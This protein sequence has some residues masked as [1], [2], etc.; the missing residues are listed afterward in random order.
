MDR[1]GMVLLSEQFRAY[2][3]T[4]SA[5]ALSTLESTMQVAFGVKNLR[6]VQ[7]WTRVGAVQRNFINPSIGTNDI[8]SRIAFVRG[9]LEDRVPSFP[10]KIAEFDS[11]PTQN[12]LKL[13]EYLANPYTRSA[14]SRILINPDGNIAYEYDM[15]GFG[16]NDDVVDEDD[17]EEFR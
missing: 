4:L 12:G 16:W 9:I 5:F 11:F 1:P 6:N 15:Y 3:Q 17:L 13:K 10:V 7:L 8:D 2:A 14:L